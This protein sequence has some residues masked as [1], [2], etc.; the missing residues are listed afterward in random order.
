MFY[1]ACHGAR[2]GDALETMGGSSE[3]IDNM[4]DIG[5]SS[6]TG[7]LNYPMLGVIEV[8]QDGNRGEDDTFDATS[9]WSEARN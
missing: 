9:S 3:C 5:T 1:V 7:I 6:S 2:E 4:E 8:C